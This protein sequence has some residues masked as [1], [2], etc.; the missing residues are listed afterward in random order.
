MAPDECNY[1][2][3]VG[4]FNLPDID[5]CLCC[6]SQASSVFLECFSDFFTQIVTQPTRDN[7]L[8]IVLKNDVTLVSNVSVEECLLG[9]V[10]YTVS[11][12]L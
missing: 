12:T 2:I 6:S 3:L 5:W 10:H 8:D 7:I 1:R 4:D 9:S 11:V